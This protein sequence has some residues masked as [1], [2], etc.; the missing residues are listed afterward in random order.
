MEQEPNLLLIGD[1][2]L[3]RHLTRYFDQLGL[4]HAAWSRRMHAEGRCPELKALVHCRT[5]ALLAIRDGAIEPFISAHPELGSAVCV[6]FSGHLASP[7]AV[8]AHPLF[9]FAGTLYQRE[10]YERIPF[11]IDQGS[12]PLCLLIPGLPN[13]SFFIE[14]ER[15]SRYHALCV[16]AGNFTT[17]LWKKLFFELDR[18]FGIAR[19]HALPYLESVTRGLAG[20]G[21]P[22][23]GP[24][25]RG[26]HATLQ[27]NLEALKDDPFEEVYQAFVSAYESRENSQGSG[28]G[29]IG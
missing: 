14:P 24:L 27:R 20:K 23:S 22:L 18:E 29:R 17:L 10:L 26:D 12:P 8:G 2:R 9:S 3:A 21:P 15:R 16:L 13:P 11:V 25:S 5:R 19:E 4:S 7:L 6:H 1:G 28:A